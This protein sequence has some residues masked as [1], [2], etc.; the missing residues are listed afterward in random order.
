MSYQESSSLLS[1]LLILRY[2][3][4]FI[5][6]PRPVIMIDLRWEITNQTVNLRG[7]AP[8][9]QMD[10]G[11]DGAHKQFGNNFKQ[12]VFISK[13]LASCSNI[14]LHTLSL[15]KCIRSSLCLNY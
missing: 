2:K 4:Q 14:E 10:A 15:Y 3:G 9:P 11:F 13:L 7:M 12:T 1:Q 6:L 5:C 8:V